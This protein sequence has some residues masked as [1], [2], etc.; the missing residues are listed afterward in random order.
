MLYIAQLGSTIPLD[1]TIEADGVGGITGQAPT[2]AIRDALT[3]GSY[4]D[5]ADGTFKLLG[6]TTK[7][8]SMTEV[9]RGHY[10]RA[11]DTSTV[12]GLV[13]GAKLA[14]EFHNAGAYV[15]DDSDEV[16]LVAALDA[17]PTAAAVAS[18]QSDTDNI[19]TRLPAS[20]S[21]GR[22]R[23][24]V[25][26]LDAGTITPTVA[27]N[28]DTTISSRASA[29]DLAAAQTD[30]DDI[31]TR[32][33]A[34]LAGGR[35]RSQVEGLDADTITAA[36]IAPAAITSSEAPALAN[37]DVAVST[38]ATQAQ[39]LSDATPFAGGF[40]D[41]AISSRST[42]TAPQVDTQ[43]S[44]THGA[45]AWD[46]ATSPAAVATAVWDEAT[47]PHVTAGTYG[48]L[49][50]T[51]LD[52][53]VSS[54]AAPGAAMALTPGERTTV[55]ALVLSDATPFP[56]ARIDATVSSRASAAALAV[57]AAAV[58]ALPD[59]TTIAAAVLEAA[60]AGHTAG[61]VGAVLDYLRMI[62]SNRLEIVGQEIWLYE[63][64][65]ITVAKKALLKDGSD[66]PV[67]PGVGE[68]AKRAPFA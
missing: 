55:Q 26:G 50:A 39:I 42:L 24:Q 9:E 44:G 41:V 33:P 43:L 58:A 53:A 7:Y 32:L 12:V 8:A 60:V 54:R 64:D 52:A 40:V 4:L 16:E 14:A 56:G 61:S 37:L 62:F 57:V 22:M 46:A 51:D 20:L 66:G 35:M 65:A 67:S 49:V 10:R 59:A 68:P 30:L 13:A 2:V 21:G 5:F 28:L 34:T 63:D 45:G 15:G 47:A 1:L 18:V 11:L 3:T 38:R 48:L 23:S 19:Q 36:V 17:L 31:Q 6:W 27:P 25:E 29:V